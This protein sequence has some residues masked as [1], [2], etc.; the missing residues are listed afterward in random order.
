MIKFENRLIRDLNRG[1]S[2]NEVCAP[3]PAILATL[4]EFE[5]GSFTQRWSN[6]I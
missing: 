4:E 1:G 3:S 5:N 2:C 6:L